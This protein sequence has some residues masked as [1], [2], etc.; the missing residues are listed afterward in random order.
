MSALLAASLAA[1]VSLSPC[2]VA[3]AAQA[4]ECGSLTV[5][6]QRDASDDRRLTL[7]FIRMPA[8]E[9]GNAPI[10]FLPGGPGQAGS[11]IV[12]IVR[13]I[14]GTSNRAHDL[15]IPDFRGTGKSGALP[16]H[17]DPDMLQTDLAASV[18]AVADCRDALQADGI[19]LSDYNSD[20]IAD[21]MAELVR[22][23]GYEQVHL[24]GGSYG[25]RAAQVIMRRHPEL[26]RSAVLDGVAPLGWAVGGRMGADAQAALEAVAAACGAQAACAVAFP[27]IQAQ[28]R[29]VVER[30]DSGASTQ[31][32]PDPR[33]GAA[34]PVTVDS[35]M[36]AGAVRGVLY[37]APLTRL[38]PWMIAQADAGNVLP[39]HAASQ[40]FAGDLSES[41]SMGMMLSVLC[42]EDISRLN[43]TAPANERN[44]FAG[45]AIRDYWRAA[46]AEWPVDAANADFDQPLD[47]N[48]P[49]LLLSGVWDPVTPPRNGD[50]LDQTLANSR[51]IVVQGTAHI[52]GYRGCMPRLIAAFYADLQPE[53]LDTGCLD[54]LETPAFMTT[55]L[56]PGAT[57]E[58][59]Q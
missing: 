20:A 52:A 31:Q 47:T 30:A 14:L 5:P 10:L 35:L 37:N 39:L 15:L 41:I 46:C 57:I 25:T 59:G 3:G 34:K 43:D 40:E 16:C 6:A 58:A 22:A 36:L 12:N 56:A 13:A 44:S 29:R 38:L 49:T 19:D 54:V 1:T 21:D 4:V 9:A 45:T 2:H 48:T 23:L 7:Q 8:P 11:D 28:L 33:S 50:Q 18:Q 42:R 53:A 26:V 27:N 24:Y 17:F 55:G 51:H 32:L